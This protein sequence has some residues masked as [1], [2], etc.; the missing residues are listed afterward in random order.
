[1]QN[2][3]RNRFGTGRVEAVVQ[4]LGHAILRRQLQHVRPVEAAVGQVFNILSRGGLDVGTGTV[5]K[6][7]P[8]WA[9]LF[10][11]ASLI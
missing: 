2:G 1:M 4:K 8:L 3:G 6:K 7:L 10:A 9:L 11:E 5:E